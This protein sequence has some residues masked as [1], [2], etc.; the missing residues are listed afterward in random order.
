MSAVS[1]HVAMRL[2]VHGGHRGRT[3]RVSTWRGLVI[4]GLIV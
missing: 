1:A 2:T 4:A 3:L